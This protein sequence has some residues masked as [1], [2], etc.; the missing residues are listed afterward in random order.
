MG[1]LSRPVLREPE[2]RVELTLKQIECLE[3]A[4]TG[5]HS[6][7]PVAMCLYPHHAFVFYEDGKIVGALD[8]CF[9]CSNISGT[10]KGYSDYWDLASLQQIIEELGMP[11]SNPRW[12]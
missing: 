11:I 7:H 12:V 1:I 5:E 4:V 8:I 3:A 6:P 9:L 2:G 10:P